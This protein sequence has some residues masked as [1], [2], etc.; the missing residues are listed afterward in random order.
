MNLED[1]PFGNGLLE[2]EINVGFSGGERKFSEIIQIISLNPKFVIFDEI[3]AG[4]DI[5]NLERLMSIIQEKLINNGIFL[6]L[7]TH[8]GNV[9]QFL[10]PDVAHVMLDG[11]IVCTSKDW[12]R[13]WKTILRYGYEKCREC[14]GSEL[15]S[16]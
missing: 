15:P 5:V 1:F 8:R 6:L 11:E 7:I 3:D 12:R 10:E 16:N 4:L 14:K 2:R 9:L 13:H